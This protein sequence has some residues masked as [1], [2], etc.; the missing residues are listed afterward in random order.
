MK[1]IL[2]IY[3]DPDS[4]GA[5]P[6]CEV[7]DA[8]RECFAHSESLRRQGRLSD[9][10]MLA[11]PEHTRTTGLREARGFTSD[12]PFVESKEILGG[13]NLIE[14]ADMEEAFRIAEGFPWGRLGRIEVRP[15]QDLEVVRARVMGMPATA[16]STGD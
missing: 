5:E 16:G 9:S 3:T 1:F 11:G 15:V 2:L 7:D 10:Q 4:L 12:G 6:P 14:A 13:F 8:L